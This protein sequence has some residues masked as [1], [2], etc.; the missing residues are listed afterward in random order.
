[1]VV[2]HALLSLSRGNYGSMLYLHIQLHVSAASIPS[3]AAL[4]VSHIQK[5]IDPQPGGREV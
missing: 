1:M 5:K 2:A 4:S 3:L